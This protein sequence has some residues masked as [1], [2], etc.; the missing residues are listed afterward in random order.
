MLGWTEPFPG[1]F[2]KDFDGAEKIYRKIS[3]SVAHLEKEH[4][5]LHCICSFRFDPSPE[6]AADSLREAWKLLRFESPGLSIV[7]DGLSK[8][9]TVPKVAEAVEQ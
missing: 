7:P 8:V 3:Q 4:W 1:V 2:R 9:Y 6:S 5:C